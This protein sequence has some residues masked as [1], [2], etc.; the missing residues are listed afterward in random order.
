MTKE[1][2]EHPNPPNSL[3]PNPIKVALQHMSDEEKSILDCL[4]LKGMSMTRT[5]EFLEIRYNTNRTNIKRKPAYQAYIR[6]LMDREAV[7]SEFGIDDPMI[8]ELVKIRDIA[9][10]TGQVTSAVRAHEICM[11]SVGRLSKEEKNDSSGKKSVEEMT[12]SEMLEELSDLKLKADGYGFEIE[13]ESVKVEKAE[14][15]A[16]DL[17]PSA[18]PSTPNEIG[19]RINDG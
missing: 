8:V 12:R 19:A 18:P 16:R 2:K 3:E 17:A 13:S 9:R 10:A 15:L 1:K 5:C 4:Y 11:K 6:H 14:L 7:I